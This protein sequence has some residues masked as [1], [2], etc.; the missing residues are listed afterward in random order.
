MACRPA[1]IRSGWRRRAKAATTGTGWCCARGAIARCAGFSRRSA[2]RSA[3]W[4]ACATARCN[5]REISRQVAGANWKIQ[6]YFKSFKEI[7]FG[8]IFCLSLEKVV[9]PVVTGMGYELVDV[10]ASGSGRLL[11]LVIDKPGGITLG[12][13]EAVSRQLTRVLVVEGIDY[14]RVEVSS[15]GLDRPLRT[16]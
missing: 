12:A 14:D 2:T 9:E 11:R 1:S 3:A 5:C 7:G 15:P 6:L 10:Q 8:P 4:S 16:A 13:C